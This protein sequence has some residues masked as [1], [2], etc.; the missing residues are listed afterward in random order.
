VNSGEQRISLRTIPSIVDL[1][2]ADFVCVACGHYGEKDT[3]KVPGDPQPQR[4]Y[5]RYGMCRV[6]GTTS[7]RDEIADVGRYYDQQ[8]YSF[9]VSEPRGLW[10]SA[11]RF[12]DRRSLFGTGFVSAMVDR[13]SA[14]PRMTSMRALFDGSL[15]QR[16]SRNSSFLD[17]GCGEGQ[18]LLEMKAIGFSKLT[19]VDPFMRQ[20]GRRSGID[21]IRGELRD[22]DGRFDVVMLHHSLEHM[23]NASQVVHD[24]QRV[25][26]NNGIVI[27]RIPLIGSWAWEEFGGEWAQMDAPR[28]VHLFTE[29]GF[30]S[31]ARSAGWKIVVVRYDADILQFTGSILRMRSINFY[32][33]LGA[34]SESFDKSE[35]AKFRR[36]TKEL[37]EMRRGDAAA[38]FLLRQ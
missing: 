24:L 1:G 18:R 17:V 22:V 36:R 11:K 14:N 16:I 15:G 9:N 5:F 23:A 8:Y 13:I 2:V 37:N 27:V 21:F 33:D 3:F 35:L 20:S 38:F 30:S 19:G 12:R 31:L 4:E 6:C 10:R 7:L 32:K 25:V 29:Q 28:H 34:A 26:G